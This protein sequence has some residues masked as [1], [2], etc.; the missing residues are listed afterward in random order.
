MHSRHPQMKHIFV[1]A[2]AG[3]GKR[4]NLGY[5]KQFLAHEGKALFLWPALCAEKCAVIDSIFV[6]APRETAE[7]IRALL[8]EEEITKLRGVAPGGKERQDSVGNALAEIEKYG[9]PDPDAVVFIQDGVRIF[10][11][12][13]YIVESLEE[14]RRDQTLDGIVIG[15]PVK[16][17]IKVVGD[18]GI[19]R[20]TP[21]RSALYAANTPQTFRYPVL[22][23]AYEKAALSGFRAT[24]D[25]ELVERIGGRVKMIRGDYDNIKITT[26]EDLWRLR[27]KE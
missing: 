7:K 16:D 21:P 10:C 2:A 6:I 25:A 5:P 15:T 8:A 17:T 19:I 27:N 20:S 13:R 24:D 22:K 18:D 1:I 26:A 9:A 11:K 4:M 12:E 3:A 23:K 14:L